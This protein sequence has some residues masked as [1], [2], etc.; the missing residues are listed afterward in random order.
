MAK[1]KAQLVQVKVAQHVVEGLCA[2]LRHK[3][4]G[5]L[6]VE[7]LVVLWKGIQNVQVLL[8]G[9]ELVD[10]QSLSIRL[11]CDTRLDDHIALVI[12]D[13]IELLGGQ[14]QQVANLVWQATEVPDV[15]YWN[16]KLN[17][18]HALTAD[19]LLGHFYA[20]SVADDSLVANPLVLAAMALIVFNGA[21]NALAE[22]A[23][24]FRLIGP[25]VDGFRLQHFA[26]AL[27]ED[28]LGRRHADANLVEV[29][30][31]LRGLVV[32]HLR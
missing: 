27:L 14:A 18:T 26:M 22:E 15:R 6:F 17:V 7:V 4:V 28:F 11:R 29:A 10:I 23:I 5:V 25:V 30:G 20:T 8:F 19:F 32:G 12:D 13:L 9:E 2:H 24:P 31:E 1:I 3:F 16:H 21:E